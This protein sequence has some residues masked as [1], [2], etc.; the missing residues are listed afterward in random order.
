MIHNHEV[1]SSILRPATRKHS[2]TLCFFRLQPS[3]LPSLFLSLLVLLLLV[4]EVA[5]L[6]VFHVVA[7]GFGDNGE[8]VGIATEE[9]GAEAPQTKISQGFFQSFLGYNAN[10]HKGLEGAHRATETSCVPLLENQAQDPSIR[11]E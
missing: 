8:E 3:G 4:G 1:R 9:A 6:H 10:G 7:Y 2:K 5:A 11:R